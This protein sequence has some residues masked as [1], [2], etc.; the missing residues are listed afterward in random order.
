MEKTYS[1]LAEELN[2]ISGVSASMVENNDGTYSLSMNVENG[3]S[4]LASSG[5][6]LAYTKSI[7]TT[8]DSEAE[9]F[10]VF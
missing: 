9:D 4:S 3:G 8:Y 7:A 6:D 10:I 1:D 5:I 2:A